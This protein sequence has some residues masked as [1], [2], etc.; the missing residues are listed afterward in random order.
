MDPDVMDP[1]SLSSPEHGGGTS[2][3]R[4]RGPG[5]GSMLSFSIQGPADHA[6]S[7]RSSSAA[8]DSFDLSPATDASTGGGGFMGRGS[9]HQRASL[10]LHEAGELT[11]LGQSHRSSGLLSPEDEEES[12]ENGPARYGHVNGGGGIEQGIQRS[13]GENVVVGIA[14]MDARRGGGGRKRA[15]EVATMDGHAS[16][17][18]QQPQQHRLERSWPL[19]HE[20]SAGREGS[21][22]WDVSEPSPSNSFS[23]RGSTPC[24]PREYGGVP[25]LSSSRQRARQGVGDRVSLSGFARRGESNDGEGDNGRDGGRGGDDGGRNSNRA[26]TS[27]RSSDEPLSG[28]TGETFSVV[29]EVSSGGLPPP[30]L[31]PS[32]PL[33][34]IGVIREVREV[35]PLD[36]PSNLVVSCCMEQHAVLYGKVLRA[37]GGQS[38]PFL[39]GMTLAVN[40]RYPLFSMLSMMRCRLWSMTATL[41]RLC[42]LLVCVC[43]AVLPHWA[44][45]EPFGPRATADSGSHASL[46]PSPGWPSVISRGL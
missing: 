3:T 44:T 27:A 33:P 40:S 2:S 5:F 29:S 32:G 35:A 19:P 12:T 38:Q 37:A 1:D 16:A 23:R 7:Q 17:R 41:R 45:A 39:R 20:R 13:R 18:W 26:G 46:K 8:L 10:S 4:E 15:R 43:A 21:Q 11:Q 28:G 31:L 22:Q 36:Y 34:A 14:P 42:H 25:H 9:R 24:S 30:P 6:S